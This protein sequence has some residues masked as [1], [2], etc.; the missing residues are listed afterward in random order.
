MFLVY[1]LTCNI[2]FMAYKAKM[3]SALAVKSKEKVLT[4]WEQVLSSNYMM[5]LPTGS[6]IIEYL[7]TSNIP[8]ERE[9]AEK[10]VLK[11]EFVFDANQPSL[12]DSMRPGVL[13]VIE[14]GY[15]T[16]DP[17][18]PCSI[19]LLEE[20]PSITAPLAFAFPQGS[21]LKAEFDRII[22]NMYEVGVKDKVLRNVLRTDKIGSCSEARQ[23][24]STRIEDIQS[25]FW[26]F[27]AGTGLSIAS[28]VVEVITWKKSLSGRRQAFQS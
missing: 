13:Y 26:L 18:Y 17:E 6:F 4:S 27:G 24:S 8:I 22:L 28:F 11:E 15:V 21:R 12:I 9:I 14:R 16:L 5:L 7:R 23:H 1:I 19:E 2:L 10:K 20:I 25:A 3:T